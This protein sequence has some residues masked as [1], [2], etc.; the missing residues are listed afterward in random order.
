MKA[1]K[2]QGSWIIFPR[3]Y[4]LVW[5]LALEMKTMCIQQQN[6]WMK[7]ENQRHCPVQS[8]PTTEDFSDKHMLTTSLEGEKLMGREVSGL[9][10]GRLGSSEVLPFL[11]RLPWSSHWPPWDCFLTFKEASRG[12]PWWLSGKEPTCRYRKHGFNL[13]SGK[14]PNTVEQLSPH[15]IT[16][17]PV[18]NSP[19]AA[20]PEAHMSQCS[21]TSEATAVRR[22]YAATGKQPPLAAPT[23]SP[24][25]T[26]KT[27][28]SH[29]QINTT[30]KRDY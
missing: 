16:T 14:M 24:H 18:C 22:P 13:W 23:E 28:H 25:T 27:Q 9:W 10:L 1:T 12:L 4:P 6:V 11:S 7:N 20:T 19:W 15:I 30:L 8:T 5:N 26:A 2:A 17:E 3:W 21:T 29:R